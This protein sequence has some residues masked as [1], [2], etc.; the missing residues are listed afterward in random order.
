MVVRVCVHVWEVH[1]TSTTYDMEA[2][3]CFEYKVGSP[4]VLTN[5]IVAYSVELVFSVST[6]K[7]HKHS[8]K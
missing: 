3:P 5:Q 2:K 1:P 7:A 4:S 6:N 8:P